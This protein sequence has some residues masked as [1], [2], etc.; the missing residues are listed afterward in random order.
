MPAPGGPCPMDFLPLSPHT[1]RG[2][3][4]VSSLFPT[5][6]LLHWARLGT[7]LRASAVHRFVPLGPQ[8]SLCCCGVCFICLLRQSPRKLQSECS[9]KG[10]DGLKAGCREDWG[11]G[12]EITSLPAFPAAL[13]KNYIYIKNIM[14]NK[15][16]VFPPIMPNIKRRFLSI[17]RERDFGH[18]W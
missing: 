5:P 1:G 14:K 8:H 3:A 6:G 7:T 9:G 13:N 16:N 4:G 12:R 18:K 2:L 10:A 11:R 17:M 15:K